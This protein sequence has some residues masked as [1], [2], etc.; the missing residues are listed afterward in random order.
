MT[1]SVLIWI[2]ARNVST[3]YILTCTA[4][5]VVETISKNCETSC[6]KLEGV[7][8][9]RC[10]S[11]LRKLPDGSMLCWKCELH[12]KPAD[13][14]LVRQDTKFW[15]LKRNIGR[16]PPGSEVEVCTCNE[17]SG[18]FGTFKEKIDWTLKSK[19]GFVIATSLDI[20]D[21]A[22]MIVENEWYVQGPESLL[23]TLSLLTD[24]K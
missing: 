13:R 7:R 11:K 9:P 12:R 1:A 2:N 4:G 24:E 16:V 23:A 15:V 6:D 8:C 10:S 3:I 19:T 17:L 22:I 14:I 20:D 18:V 5:V 21:L